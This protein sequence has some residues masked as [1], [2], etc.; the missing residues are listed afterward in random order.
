M[1]AE[2]GYK[3]KYNEKW[4]RYLH[5]TGHDTYK[6]YDNQEDVPTYTMEK[7]ETIRSAICTD[8]NISKHEITLV[9]V[10]EITKK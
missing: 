8:N 3:L 9:D 5:M 2:Q 4:I 1:M 7:A 10:G 6:L